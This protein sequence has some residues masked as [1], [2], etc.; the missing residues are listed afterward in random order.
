MG[1]KM[2]TASGTFLRRELFAS[3]SDIT[4]RSVLLRERPSAP[5]GWSSLAPSPR[6][7][8]MSLGKRLLLY[9]IHDPHADQLSASTEDWGCQVSTCGS[10]EQLRGCLEGAE[11]DMVLVEGSKSLR[12]LLTDHDAEA[13][14]ASVPLSEIEKRHILRVLA[15]TQGNKTQAARILGIDTKT[16]YNKLKAYGPLAGG[17]MRRA[18][19]R[20]Q[21]NGDGA[22]A[23]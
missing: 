21:A 4:H 3:Q 7:G 15:S 6:S 8:H 11:Y 23:L 9:S 2:H 12:K 22:R 18:G 13:D 5:P 1:A 14:L 20:A 16:L 17:Y 10:I 19:G